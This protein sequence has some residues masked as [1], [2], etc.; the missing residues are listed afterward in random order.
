MMKKFVAAGLTAVVAVALAVVGVAAPASAH[1]TGLSGVATC[2]TTSGTWSVQWSLAV[3]SV[4]DGVSSTTAVTVT[5]PSGSTL[6]GAS[7]VAQGGAFYVSVQPSDAAAHPGVQ[8]RTGSWGPVLFTQTGIAGSVPQASVSVANTFS[9]GTSTTAAKKTYFGGTC[10][11]PAA[12]AA[13]TAAVTTT[14]PTCTSAATL[15]LGATTYADWGTPSYSAHDYSV[16]AT[17]Q[18]DHRFVDGT[19]V[20]GDGKTKTFTGTL[21]P[22]LTEN[23]SGGPAPDAA[24]SVSVTPP[25][26]TAPGKLVYGTFTNAT[27]TSDSTPDGSTGP[28]NYRVTV[29]GDSGHVFSDSLSTH[30]LTGF[31]PAQLPS[32]S[33]SPSG[34]CYN[35]PPPTLVTP[36]A[37]TFTDVCGTTDDTYTLPSTTGEHYTFTVSDTTTNGVRTVVVTAVPDA[38][39]ALS[40]DSQSPWTFVY[41]NEECPAPPATIVVTPDASS[42]GTTSADTDLTS[43]VSIQSADHVS[44]AIYPAGHPEQ[45]QPLTSTFTAE[46]QGSYTVVATAD[47]GYTLTDAG[48]TF[49]GT[50]HEFAVDVFDTLLCQLP[51]GAVYDA[52]ASG[53]PASCTATTSDGNGFILLTHVASQHSKGKIQYDIE[54]VSTGKV[55]HAGSQATK[56]SVQPGDYV[57]TASAVDAVNDGINGD[58]VFNVT[59]GGASTDCVDAPPLTPTS[60]AFTGASDNAGLGLGLAGGMLVLGLAGL[61]IRHRLVKRGA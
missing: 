8:T 34:P 6:S 51:T 33:T 54:S 27:A 1:T 9:D 10:A 25:T 21:A 39:Y 36:K 28:V 17:A 7:G 61:Y 56:V 60:L 38:G 18:G 53:T 37:P 52:G 11:P 48:N 15:K 40:P 32:Q 5:A 4:P 19:G 23:C 42:C 30:T 3:G 44:W 26:C 59:V 43:W 29:V 14:A 49:V 31:V 12:P 13:A 24:A 55:I 41:T 47:D 45:S 50:S 57:V 35:A 58:T 20:S 2:D 46:E 22:K 16:V